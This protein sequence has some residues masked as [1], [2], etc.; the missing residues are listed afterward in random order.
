VIDVDD[1]ITAVEGETCQMQAFN[2]TK[3]GTERELV[4]EAAASLELPRGL[5][6]D[7]QIQ[8]WLDGLE[9]RGWTTAERTSERYLLRHPASGLQVDLQA[10]SFDPADPRHPLDAA[11]PDM[12]VH[13]AFS[14]VRLSDGSGLLADANLA[15]AQPDGSVSWLIARP[16][17]NPESTADDPAA[18]TA[19]A[20]PFR[21]RG[22]AGLNTPVRILVAISG[23]LLCTALIGSV[24]GLVLRRTSATSVR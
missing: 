5:V 10:R 23:L 4:E 7:D 11:P 19:T 13:Y 8:Q 21:R 2:R 12:P 9:A 20:S 3:A 22:L 14:T 18:T 6:D 1:G 24:I 15:D 16:S 17:P